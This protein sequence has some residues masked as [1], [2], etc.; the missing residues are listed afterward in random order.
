M[1]RDVISWGV[2]VT[3]VAIAAAACWV[4]GASVPTIVFVMSGIA[5][6]CA[7]V[8]KKTLAEK[9]CAGILVLSLLP[10]FAALIASPESSSLSSISAEIRSL[11]VAIY[12]V[13]AI[14]GAFLLGGPHASS[15][16]TRI[17]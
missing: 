15:K 11:L 16:E 4:L 13:I 14:A 9:L 1:M 6:L 5:L 12:S 10:A 17:E 2:V 7:R 8:W 3:Y